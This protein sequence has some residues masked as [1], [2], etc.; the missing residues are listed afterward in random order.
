MLLPIK[1]P[2]DYQLDNTPKDRICPKASENYLNSKDLREK[3]DLQKGKP[4]GSH[5]F[6]LKKETH[7]HR[8]ETR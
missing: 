2:A 3:R 4:S 6:L 1:L 5:S 7:S 8:Q